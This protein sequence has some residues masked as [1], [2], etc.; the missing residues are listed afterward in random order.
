MHDD[1]RTAREIV[2][3]P[4][5]NLPT[6]MVTPDGE[7]S[8]DPDALDDTAP[9]RVIEL[10][11]KKEPE[12]AI[13]MPV[14]QPV[15]FYM[16]EIGVE[17]KIRVRGEDLPQVPT[18]MSFTVCNFKFAEP[19]RVSPGA[20]YSFKFYEDGKT[21]AAQRFVVESDTRVGWVNIKFARPGCKGARLWVT[22][23]YGEVVLATST[24][25]LAGRQ[26]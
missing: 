12:K 24:K 20:V 6:A 11:K 17:G 21:R 4:T 22:L 3:A 23:N 7:Y 1:M 26:R 2:E 25:V 19:V 8:Y 16:A 18:G 13:P 10:G 5:E 15:Y 14:L 9:A